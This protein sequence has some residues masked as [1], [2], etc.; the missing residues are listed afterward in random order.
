MSL[1]SDSDCISAEYLVRADSWVSGQGGVGSDGGLNSAPAPAAATLACNGA[2]I[3][4]SGNTTGEAAM[5]PLDN[6]GRE[7]A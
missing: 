2:S 1:V 6:E 4:S 3:S 5:N 7:L